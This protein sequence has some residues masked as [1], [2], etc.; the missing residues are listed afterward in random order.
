MGCGFVAFP[1]L[2]AAVNVMCASSGGCTSPSLSAGDFGRPIGS[3][4]NLHFA[5]TVGGRRERI[6]RR[7]D[8]MMMHGGEEGE[9]GDYEFIDCGAGRRIERFGGVSLSLRC[10]NQSKPP[11]W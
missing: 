6:L 11:M 8:V 2:M 4:F 3:C 7:G 10:M 5:G 9:G 1:G